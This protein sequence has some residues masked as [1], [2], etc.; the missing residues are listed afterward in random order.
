MISL[1]A[2]CRSFLAYALIFHNDRTLNCRPQFITIGLRSD[3]DPAPRPTTRPS[4]VCPPVRPSASRGLSCGYPTQP[5]SSRIIGS[6][7]TGNGQRPTDRPSCR[8]PKAP[9]IRIRYSFRRRAGRRQAK[10]MDGR[11]TDALGTDEF[12]KLHHIQT[13]I[14]AMQPPLPL[15]TTTMTTIAQRLLAQLLSTLLTGTRLQAASR[16]RAPASP[17][18]AATASFGLLGMTSIRRR[19]MDDMRTLHAETVHLYVCA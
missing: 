4:P 5:R 16:Q 19:R 1:S 17:A 11:R 10:R 8:R 6:T 12:N 7:V 2:F 9:L 15:Y 13:T 14:D 3:P 18:T